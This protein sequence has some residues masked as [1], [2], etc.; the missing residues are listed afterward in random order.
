MSDHD[1]VAQSI[2][3]FIGGYETASSTITNALYELTINL[4]IQER[5]HQELSTALDGLDES[6]DE[7]YDTVMK[8]IPYLDAV[9]NESL[10]K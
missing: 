7:Y 8:D 5:L 3:F 10:R 2:L 9:I 4:D 6:S 1:I